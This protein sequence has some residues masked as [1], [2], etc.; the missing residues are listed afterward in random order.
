MPFRWSNSARM[1][2]GRRKAA[3]TLTFW[4]GTFLFGQN[5]FR[6]P[7]SSPT[8][9]TIAGTDGTGRATSVESARSHAGR[10]RVRAS[11]RPPNQSPP[12]NIPP[13]SPTEDITMGL[14]IARKCVLLARPLLPCPRL[15]RL[16]A[17]ITPFRVHGNHSRQTRLPPRGWPRG[18][19]PAERG[20]LKRSMSRPQHPEFLCRRPRS[21][22]VAGRRPAFRPPLAWVPRA[23]R[24]SLLGPDGPPRPRLRSFVPTALG[25][26]TFCVTLRWRPTTSV[27]AYRVINR[28]GSVQKN[29]SPLLTV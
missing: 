20:C 24:V 13:P 4:S 18:R 6:R 28:A 29:K 19:S 11:R 21:T 27:S 23:R 10:S 7:R 2:C 12:R 25:A 17:P 26:L 3:A 14:K 5:G 22:S 1:R 16:P 9:L 8:D 15:C